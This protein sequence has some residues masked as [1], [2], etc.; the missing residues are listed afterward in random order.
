M[1]QATD[2]RA[3]A[4]RTNY[5]H[6]LLASGHACT[7]TEQAGALAFRAGARV[8]LTS[9]P[10]P[11]THT[12]RHTEVILTGSSCQQGQYCSKGPNSLRN[13]AQQPRPHAHRQMHARPPPPRS[14]PTRAQPC[15]RP[16]SRTP[17][18]H[19][20]CRLLPR[21]GHACTQ[22]RAAAAWLAWR[23]LRGL[24]PSPPGP[25]STP[26]SLWCAR[27]GARRLRP[28]PGRWPRSAAGP[29]PPPRAPTRGEGGGR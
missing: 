29:A 9:P 1:E 18:Q 20:W 4:T 12:H 10:P 25:P 3:T 14:P 13:R 21:P 11:H 26:R 6:Q 27:G 24:S 7:G 15:P 16:S 2:A 23:G 22:S 28:R 8:T 17:P 5:P 19:H